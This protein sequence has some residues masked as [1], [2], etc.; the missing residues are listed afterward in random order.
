MRSAEA[1]IDELVEEAL[2]RYRAGDDTKLI[3]MT[4]KVVFPRLIPVAPATARKS[5]CT[6]ILLGQPA[7]KFIRRGRSIRYRFQDVLDWLEDANVYSSTLEAD[8][9]RRSE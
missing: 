4:E 3:E 8:L 9:N 2:S 5:R 6:G 7:P 1:S